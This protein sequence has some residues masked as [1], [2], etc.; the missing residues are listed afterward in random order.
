MASNDRE[1][2]KAISSNGLLLPVSFRPG[3]YT[4][5]VGRGKT[6]KENP[7]NVRLVAAAQNLLS[8]YKQ[9]NKRMKTRVVSHILSQIYEA[10]PNGG[11]FVKHGKDGRWYEVSPSAARERVTYAFRDLLSDSYK[12]SSKSKV[13]RRRSSKKLLEGSDESSQG[14]CTNYDDFHP[15]TRRKSSID[16]EK[17]AKSM[18]R[19]VLELESSNDSLQGMKSMGLNQLGFSNGGFNCNQQTAVMQPPT[20]T[21]DSSLKLAF[22]NTL[23]NF[24]VAGQSFTTGGNKGHQSRNQAALLYDEDFDYESL[25]WAPMLPEC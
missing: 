20:L 19:L 2:K 7:G 15:T 14:S 6:P 4:I 18:T 10:N 21:R 22:D 12:S 11:A 25:L 9:D 13:E 16:V 3:P 24:P 5:I 23:R 8:K 17:T 1:N